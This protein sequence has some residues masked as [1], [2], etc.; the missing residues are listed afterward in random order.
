MPIRFLL[1]AAVMIISR[2]VSADPS[3]IAVHIDETGAVVVPVTINGRGPFPFLLDT[4]SSHSVVSGSLAEQ[5][6]A[7]IRRQDIG[8]HVDRPR[9][10]PL[11]AEIDA[12]GGARV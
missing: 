8:G 2:P 3:E 10:R 6:C 12:I 7:A 5:L 4:G 11:S 9:V 1:F